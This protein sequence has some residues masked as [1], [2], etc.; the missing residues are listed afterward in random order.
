MQ[1]H[2]QA[3]QANIERVVVGK[4]DVVRL[5]I[6]ALLAEG[7]LLIEDVPGV[8]KTTLAHALAKSIDCSFQRIQCTSDMLPSDILGVSVFNQQTTRFEFQ[9][10]PIFGNVVLADEINRTTPKTQSSLL[11]AMSERQISVDGVTYPLNPPFM[12]LATQNP[13]EYHGTYPLPESQ[14]DRFFM[15]IRMGYPSADYEKAIMRS[16]RTVAALEHLDPVLTK[17][18]VLALQADVDQVQIDESLQEYIVALAAKTRESRW[19]ELGVSPRGTLALQR[20]ARA[21]ALLAGRSYCLP[22]DI[23]PLITPVFAHRIMLSAETYT[24]AATEDTEHIVRDIVE[25]TPVPL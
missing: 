2:I 8:G 16:E 14:L 19:L 4:S 18:E 7:H 15:R 3:L 17:D 11:E 25:D 23:K 10:G 24:S 13:L 21:A 6:I 5:A 12:V 20:A 1:H 22:D 9:P